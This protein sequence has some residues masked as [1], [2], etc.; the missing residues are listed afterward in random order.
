MNTQATYGNLVFSSGISEGS[1]IKDFTAQI[2]GREPWP[3]EVFNSSHH[4]GSSEKLSQY[5]NPTIAKVVTEI[6][7]DD[8]MN[9]G[10]PLWNGLADNFILV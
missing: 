1:S 6:V 9:F 10:Y 3:S 5:Y 8:L 2:S 4:R 7:Y